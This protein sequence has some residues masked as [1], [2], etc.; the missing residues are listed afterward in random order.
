MSLY[1]ELGISSGATPAAIKKAYRRLVKKC[2]PDLGGDVERFKAISHAYSVLIDPE[3]RAA[4][5]ANGDEGRPDN[6]RA[7]ALQLISA[8]LSTLLSD[9]DR[10]VMQNVPAAML[11]ILE[12]RVKSQRENVATMR[13][14]LAT[15]RKIVGRFKPKKDHPDAQDVLSPIL[16]TRLRDG[17]ENIALMEKDIE[18]G[19]RAIDMLVGLDDFPLTH[20]PMDPFSQNVLLTMMRSVV[21]DDVTS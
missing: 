7:D 15:V 5:D 4:Y 14:N 19:Q 12:G 11:L 18:L 20:S 1:V 13:K 8:V 3:K 10:M 2:H 16:E 6:A 21:V 9:P 17:E